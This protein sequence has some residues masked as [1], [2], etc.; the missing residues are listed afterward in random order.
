MTLLLYVDKRII[1]FTKQLQNTDNISIN[2]VREYYINCVSVRN[3]VTPL[4]NVIALFPPP[5]HCK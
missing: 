2:Q 5:L 4:K 1:K 3:I